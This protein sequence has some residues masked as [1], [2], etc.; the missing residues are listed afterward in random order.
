MRLAGRS[1]PQDPGIEPARFEEFE[2]IPE[3][4]LVLGAGLDDLLELLGHRRAIQA[5]SRVPGHW[6]DPAD[7]EYGTEIEFGGR[8]APA[9]GCRRSPCGVEPDD[10]RS[11]GAH[12]DEGPLHEPGCMHR[13]YGAPVTWAEA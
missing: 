1:L 2:Q 9:D 12:G 4:P 10:L 13:V 5:L 7:L 6:A 8:S 11:L 3:F